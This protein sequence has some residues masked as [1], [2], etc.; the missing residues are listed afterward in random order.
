LVY[1]REAET[2]W[3]NTFWFGVRVYKCPLDLWVYQ[4]IIHETKPDVV[5]ET[6]TLF[7]GSALFFAGM[8]DLLGKGRVIP[9]DLVCQPGR[10]DYNR[11]TY[12]TGSSTSYE[13][14]GH[15]QELVAGVNN[16]MVVLDSDH[17][18]PHYCR[19]FACIHLW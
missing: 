3:T 13:V 1:Y 7:G 11:I 18:A 6:G 5:I 4:E 16:V 10:P 8:L 9:I 14:I 2:T 12:I 17:K 19:R 15:V